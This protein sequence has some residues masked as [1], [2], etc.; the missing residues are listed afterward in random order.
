MANAK[1]DNR[2]AHSRLG[3]E[4]VGRASLEGAGR[5]RAPSLRQVTPLARSGTVAPGNVFYECA[6]SPNTELG[7]NGW[8]I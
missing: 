2:I 1:H 4:L 3:Q 8:V 6:T 7:D 5:F